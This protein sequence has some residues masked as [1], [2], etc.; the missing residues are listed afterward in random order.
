MDIRAIITAAQAPPAPAEKNV[1]EAHSTAV[2]KAAAAHAEAAAAQTPA[3]QAAPSAGQV[4]Q[5]VQS[6][7]KMLQQQ[8]QGLEFSIDADSNKTI[9][10]VVDQATKEVIRQIPSVEV[11]EIA[12]ALGSS[13][14][15]M[16]IRQKA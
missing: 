5:A 10:K 4:T 7:N 16:L 9:I 14:Q 1:S 11:M 3:Q 15:G 13:Q 8:A 6:I 2:A 12:K